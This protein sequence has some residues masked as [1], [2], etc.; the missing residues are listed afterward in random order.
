M[1]ELKLGR[2]KPENA[3]VKEYY[4][5]KLLVCGGERIA[6]I[7]SKGYLYIDYEKLNKKNAVYLNKFWDSY[8]NKVYKGRFKDE[9]F[10]AELI[11]ESPDF[12][13]NKRLDL[14]SGF[15]RRFK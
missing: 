8:K 11:L 13:E 4:G 2:C 6:K 12:F 3:M 14:L 1:K 15:W 5:N 7:S 10:A 9:I